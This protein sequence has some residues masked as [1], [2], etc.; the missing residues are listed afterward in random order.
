V[1][2]LPEAE[3]IARDLDGALRGAVVRSARVLRSDVLRDPDSGGRALRGHHA[4]RAAGAMENQLTG[5]VVQRVFR[6]AKSIVLEL[7][8]SRGLSDE[9]TRPPEPGLSR[10]LVVT[11]RFTGALLID[12]PEDDP[13]ACLVAE[14][15]DGRRLSYRDIRRLGTL[16]L[17][18]ETEFAAWD[19]TLGPEPLDPSLTVERFSGIL[20]GSERA[21]KSILMDQRR[22]AGVGNIYANEACWR[23]GVRPSRRARSLTRAESAA[24]FTAVREVLTESIALRGT[25]FRDFQDAYGAR[26]GFAAKLAVYGRGGLPCPRCGAALRE[27]HKLEGRTTVWCNECQR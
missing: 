5:A 11:P 12:P 8:P 13:Y 15:A 16:S 14:L 25:T 1:P 26:G 3:T 20:R 7:A 22:L 27:T 10:R 23:A 17:L 24:L 19:A 9:L 6:R 2:E 4:A 21:V 18:S